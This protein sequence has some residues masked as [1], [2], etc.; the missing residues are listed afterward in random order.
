VDKA[1]DTASVTVQRTSTPLAMTWLVR[2]RCLATIPAA[3]DRTAHADSKQRCET[4]AWPTWDTQQWQ[5]R[6][7]SNHQ[8]VLQT[9]QGP[10]AGERLLNIRKLRKKKRA[11][12]LVPKPGE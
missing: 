2:R 5:R 1:S 7:P 10:W 9:S 3:S 12:C 11:P 6:L 8:S 4:H